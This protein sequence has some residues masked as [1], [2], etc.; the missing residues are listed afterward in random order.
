MAIQYQMVNSR[1]RYI[2]SSIYGFI[3][4]HIVNNIFII[5]KLTIDLKDVMNLVDIKGYF[6]TWERLQGEKRRGKGYNYT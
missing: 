3:K 2:I 5:I 6:Y 4:L 1:N